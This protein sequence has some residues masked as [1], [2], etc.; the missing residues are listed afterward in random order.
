MSR[1]LLGVLLAGALTVA[2]L[3]AAASADKPLDEVDCAM[4][5]ETLEELAT[6]FPDLEG[7][8]LGQL[9]S[10]LKKDP[11]LAAELLNGIAFLSGGEIVFD[12]VSQGLTTLAKCG[13]MPFLVHL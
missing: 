3:P 1:R 7:V 5:Q 8:S 13:L 2:L 6:E 12:S 10:M 4:L 9:V 11:D